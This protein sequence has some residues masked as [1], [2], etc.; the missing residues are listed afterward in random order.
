[1][2]INNGSIFRYSPFN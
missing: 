1:V 2:S